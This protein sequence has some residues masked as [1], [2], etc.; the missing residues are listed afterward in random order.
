MGA[1]GRLI[2][3]LHSTGLWIKK[4]KIP[5][6]IP[7]SM[8]KK[9]CSDLKE[10]GLLAPTH[11]VSFTGTSSSPHLPIGQPHTSWNSLQAF[12]NSLLQHSHRTLH[13]LTVCQRSCSHP[14]VCFIYFPMRIYALKSW[15]HCIFICVPRSLTQY[16]HIASA[17]SKFV[18]EIIV[19]TALRFLVCN[20][21]RS[22]QICI[23]IYITTFNSII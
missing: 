9:M 6:I 18:L 5:Q 1:P 23:K 21:Y 15:E 22:R 3:S 4:F 10:L 8:A 17:R 12:P 14:H 7:N 16:Y 2:P 13:T 19:G 11:G 20:I